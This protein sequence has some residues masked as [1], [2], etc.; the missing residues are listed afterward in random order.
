MGYIRQMK[1]G[2]TNM[3]IE[4]KDVCCAINNL[5]IRMCA[6]DVYYTNFLGNR[7]TYNN[8]IWIDIVCK[9]KAVLATYYMNENVKKLIYFSY[10]IEQLNELLREVSNDILVELVCKNENPIHNVFLESGFSCL[11]PLIRKSIN[12]DVDGKEFRCSAKDELEPYYAPEFGEIAKI[13]DAGEIHDLLDRVF[14]YRIDD[15]PSVE[16]L[17]EFI[18]N[19]WVL[20][21][22]KNGVIRTLY[23]YQ[24]KGK[25]FFSN[26][27]YNT[28]PAIALYCLEKRAH[29]YVINNYDVKVKYSWINIENVKSLRR[30]T[31]NIDGIYRY[32]Y[33]KEKDKFKT[34]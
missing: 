15:I 34:V 11:G 10:D 18:I 26:Y 16:Q 27:S 3:Q 24:V 2:V 9:D 32:V 4:Y 30:N 23:I 20:L 1:L 8:C 25:R 14:D 21:Y 22:R 5:K 12:L 7:S 29:E 6:K 17:R 13:S 19:Q 28:L 33:V 31:S